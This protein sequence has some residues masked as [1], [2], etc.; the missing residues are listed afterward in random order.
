[1]K[2]MQENGVDVQTSNWGN[3]NDVAL[4]E[5]RGYYTGV[6]STGATNGFKSTSEIAGTNAGLESYVLLTTGSTEQVK[7]QNLYDVAGNLWEWTMET[8]YYASINYNNNT[9]INTYVLR[10]GCFSHV[11]TQFPAVFRGCSYAPNTNTTYG[12]RTT[13]YIK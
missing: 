12:F 4:T 9:N 11:R 7:K 1:M 8:S 2:Y 3:Y 5:L 6:T 10:G 13:L